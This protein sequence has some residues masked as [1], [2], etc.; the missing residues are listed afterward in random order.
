MSSLRAKNISLPFFGNLWLILG[1]SRSQ[2]GRIAIV[3]DVESGMR[4]TL[5]AQARMRR[6]VGR[7]RTAKSCGPGL[8]TLRSSSAGRFAGRRRLTSPAL[9]GEHEAAVKT[10][11]QGMPDVSAYPR[12][13]TRVLSTL[14]T[15]PRVR[16][17]PGIPCALLSSRAAHNA[18]S[19]H[20]VPRECERVPLPVHPSNQ[21][22]ASPAG[23]S[24]HELGSC[25][26][27]AIG[28]RD[29]ASENTPEKRL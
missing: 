5:H 6:R 29:Q 9:R 26:I 11:A 10:I 23:N 25:P 1:V 27:S 3:T 14:H 22:F 12:F 18:S 20:F 24:C 19:G 8:P 21:V 4:W 15:R 28:F 13:R 16:R 7:K 17:A 2:E